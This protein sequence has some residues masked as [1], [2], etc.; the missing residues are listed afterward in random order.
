MKHLKYAGDSLRLFNRNIDILKTAPRLTQKEIKYLGDL[1]RFNIRYNNTPDKFND[2]TD[3]IDFNYIKQQLT[4]DG[5]KALLKKNP[6]L[7]ELFI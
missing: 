6:E 3:L 4:M 7:M 2:T 5:I 1:K